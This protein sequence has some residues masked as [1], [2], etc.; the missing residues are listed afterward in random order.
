M[1]TF[2]L[3][4]VALLSCG[5]FFVGVVV[6]KFAPHTGILR[7]SEQ[8]EAGSSPYTFIS[9]LLYCHDQN[10]S[11]AAVNALEDAIRSAIDSEKVDHDL[12]DIG[13]YFRDLSEGPWVLVNP[14][15]KSIPASLLK[16]PLAITVYERAER[17]PSFLATKVELASGESQ[18]V[19]R[20]EF[21]Q[22][23]E[24]IQPGVSY[25]IEDITR[26]MLAESDNA[27]LY[28]FGRLFSV[29]E[30]QDSYTRLGIRP[31]EVGSQGYTMDVK[32]YASFFRILYNGTYLTKAD[33][34][35][36]LS[37]LARS[38]FTQGLV[39]GVPEGIVVAHKFGEMRTQDGALQLHDCGIVYKPKHP[40]LI[41][42]MTKGR[43]YAALARVISQLSQIT[44]DKIRD[45]P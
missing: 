23:K 20:N 2:G 17:D 5:A 41:C 35:H 13:Y 34:N 43:D 37:L 31:P 19:D 14:D 45:T 33:S 18:D 22:P 7:H 29:D 6:G 3:V 38:S 25:T 12:S 28:L 16:V 11:T 27:A 44:Y 36:V 40:Y 26:Y 42:V 39:A 1:K 8:L 10:I 24:R 15:F 32:T 21:F 4:C 30:L 9:P